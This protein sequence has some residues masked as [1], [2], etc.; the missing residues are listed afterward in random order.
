[1][2]RNQSTTLLLVS[3]CDGRVDFKSG[4][5]VELSATEVI[6]PQAD[7]RQTNF[8]NCNFTDGKISLALESNCNLAAVRASDEKQGQDSK[9]SSVGC[10][11]VS[12]NMF[13]HTEPHP[14][15]AVHQ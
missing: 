15:H 4:Y 10:T 2:H 13:V 8:N 7:N 9:K 12:C 14:S 3:V 11:A 1:M 6:S 5:A